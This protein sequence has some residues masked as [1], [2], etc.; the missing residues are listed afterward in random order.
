MSTT[1]EHSSPEPHAGRQRLAIVLVAAGRGERI[2]GDVPK[3]FREFG[4][5]PLFLHSLRT[6]Q[7]TQLAGRS[8][9]VVPRG[10][11][12]RVRGWLQDAHLDADAVVAGGATRQES[13]QR[14]LQA[15]RQHADW[16]CTHV[17][18]HD[19][20]RPFVS[21]DMV[22]AVAAAVHDT[23]AAT[24]AVPVSDTLMRARPTQG[25]ATA[26]H[27]G[28]VVDRGGMWAIQTPQVFE[29]SLLERAHA[30]A[31]SGKQATDDGSLVLALGQQVRFITGAWWNLKLTHPEDF[32]KAQLI[33]AM[34]QLRHHTLEDPTT[35]GGGAA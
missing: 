3:Q 13:V 5:E 4:G 34:R 32:D 29:L 10:W 1:T 11:E 14:G 2:G 25:S 16:S 23:G 9:V 24:L 12:D 7:R 18:I 33:A 6:L 30:A 35:S 20:A 8:I 15:I 21:G 26:S 22:R 27:A 17:L 19:A 31:G 28:E